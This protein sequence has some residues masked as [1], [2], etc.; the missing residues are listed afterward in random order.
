MFEKNHRQELRRR[1]GSG[2]ELRSIKV[3]AYPGPIRCADRRRC[4]ASCGMRLMLAFRSSSTL[5]LDV[6]S[7]S[8]VVMDDF[9][10]VLLSRMIWPPSTRP[11]R[12]PPTLATPVSPSTISTPMPDPQ[13]HQRTRP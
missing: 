2:A 1:Y 8:R 10:S 9:R 13:P 12:G 4:A 6:A 7:D 3:V 11:A 5:A